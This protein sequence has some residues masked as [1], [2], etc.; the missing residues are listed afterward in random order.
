M[1]ASFP[2]AFPRAGATVEEELY[3]RS[4]SA[5]RVS[6]EWNYKNLKQLWSLNG[7]ARALK[8][9]QVLIGLLYKKSAFI[10]YFKISLEA[11]GQVQ[12]HFKCP[13][14]LSHYGN[15]E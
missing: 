14:T 5:V 3:N 8:V 2:R 4:M 11:G 9:R 1:Q 7:F 13:P 10:I 6:D 15:A 12:A